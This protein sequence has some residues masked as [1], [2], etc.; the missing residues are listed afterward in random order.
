MLGCQKWKASQKTSESKNPA[1]VMPGVQRVK[2]EPPSWHSPN[3]SDF[4]KA[5]VGNSLFF[6][7]EEQTYTGIHSSA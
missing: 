2:C 4:K 6:D 3:A 1:T 5:R 7:H